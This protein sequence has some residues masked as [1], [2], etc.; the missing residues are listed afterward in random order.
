MGRTASKVESLEASLSALQSS[1]DPSGVGPVF[2]ERPFD[3]LSLGRFLDP[4]FQKLRKSELRRAG[5]QRASANP[6]IGTS[7]GAPASVTAKAIHSFRQILHSTQFCFWMSGAGLS[8]A[9]LFLAPCPCIAEIGRSWNP[10][11]PQ[12]L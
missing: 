5:L 3:A 9:G 4:Y 1:F 12:Q 8:T 2:S 10:R 7:H 6:V 11:A